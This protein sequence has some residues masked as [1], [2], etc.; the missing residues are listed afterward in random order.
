MDKT[1]KAKARLKEFESFSPNFETFESLFWEQLDK[2]KTDVAINLLLQV[3][4]SLLKSEGEKF[5]EVLTLVDESKAKELKT[6]LDT[7][8]SKL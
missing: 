6:W 3:T 4:F 5:N 8:R 7:T 2:S 1:Q